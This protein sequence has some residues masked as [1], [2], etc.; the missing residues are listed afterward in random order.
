MA[1]RA[2]TQTLM[3]TCCRCVALP[4]MGQR[5][6]ASAVLISIDF[7][8]VLRRI[9]AVSSIRSPGRISM[10]SSS[11]PF[12]NESSC[13]ISRPARCALTRKVSNQRRLSASG[14][15]CSSMRMESSIGD[16]SL[17]RS[18]AIPLNNLPKV[19]IRCTRSNCDWIV[20]CSVISVL[21]IR[22]DR[23]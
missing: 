22:T 17:L 4:T 12:I 15:L 16:N 19:S 23:G 11:M 6:L 5:S 9:S 10:R 7:G 1:S 3:N 21:A 13:V 14:C 8:N 2:F 20:F 18:C